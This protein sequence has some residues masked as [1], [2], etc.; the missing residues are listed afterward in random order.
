MGPQGLQGEVGA[1][2]PA[3]A[4]GPQ[5]VAGPPSFLLLGNFPDSTGG[6]FPA[7]GD[8]I[9]KNELN[10]QVLVPAGAV[11][12]LRMTLGRQLASG[13]RAAA[14]VRRNGK[15]TELVCRIDYPNTEC[16]EE[17]EVSFAAGDLLSVSYR[18]VDVPDTRVIILLEFV[19]SP[20]AG[21]GNSSGTEAAKLPATLD[22]PP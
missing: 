2:G 11:R 3:G 12:S 14:A 8:Q 18:E 1:P 17:L 4:V 16:S 9:L 15:D 13:G 22:A 6:F 19:S 20:S 21:L 5:G 7:N 10:T